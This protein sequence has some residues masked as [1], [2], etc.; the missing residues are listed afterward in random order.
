MTD[1]H[2]LKSDW[3][4]IGEDDPLFGVLTQAD[5]RGRRWQFAEFMA[6]GESDV[7]AMLEFAAANGVPI[8][9]G[10]GLD[11][12]C[13]VGRLTQ[14]L[15]REFDSVDG[16]DISAPM[17]KI[18]RERNAFPDRCTYH[19]LDH[20]GRLPFADGTFDFVGSLITLQHMQPEYACGYLAEFARMLAP[21]GV[22]VFQIPAV[23]LRRRGWLRRRVL[24]PAE[25][26]LRRLRH[27]VWAGQ[28]VGS[29]PSVALRMEMHCVPEADVVR[30]LEASGVEVIRVIEDDAAGHR[31]Q[32]L[33]YLARRPAAMTDVHTAD[34]NRA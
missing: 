7:G 24:I 1:L 31:F 6:T 10:R 25:V 5:K 19:E 8:H 28:H 14:S 30:T 32:S 18:A 3:T 13:G 15:C 21:E 16:V 27:V 11:F 34:G 22:M 17:L 9:R 12:G 2:M 20:T 23:C 33:R 29:R 4:A 26:R